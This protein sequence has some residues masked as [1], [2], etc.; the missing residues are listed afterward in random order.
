MPRSALGAALQLSSLPLLLACRQ[1]STSQIRSQPAFS[2]AVSSSGLAASSDVTIAHK[3][4]QL[5]KEMAKL[6]A[7]VARQVAEAARAPNPRRVRGD[8]RQPAGLAN[9]ARVVLKGADEDRGTPPC[10]DQPAY[11]SLVGNGAMA[12]Q[13]S[14][15]PSRTS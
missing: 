1:R 14:A 8:L 12:L 7:Y 5:E 3:Y 4:Q 2:R 15:A 13:H 11:L 10:L 9:L 6:K